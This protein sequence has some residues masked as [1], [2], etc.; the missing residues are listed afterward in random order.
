MLPVLV[1]DYL[2]KIAH[3]LPS[4]VL[5][6]PRVF[7]LYLDWLIRAFRLEWVRGAYGPSSAGGQMSL[8]EELEFLTRG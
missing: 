4:R 8:G 3:L 7:H 5:D 2:L 1:S 6:L